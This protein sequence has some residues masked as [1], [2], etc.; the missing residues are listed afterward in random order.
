[1]SPARATCARSS[2]LK[3]GEG[4]VVG[5]VRLGPDTEQSGWGHKAL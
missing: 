4:M 5:L 1:M 2:G 3:C